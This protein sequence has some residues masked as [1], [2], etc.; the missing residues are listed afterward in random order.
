MRGIWKAQFK[1]SFCGS[2]FE[3]SC[4]IQMQCSPRCR[5]LT[6][7]EHVRPDERG[8][9]LWPKSRNVQTGYG[10]FPNWHEGKRTTLY[11]HRMAYEVANGHIPKGMRVLHKC[12]VRHC[13]NPSHLFLGTD[14][15]NTYDMA[16]KGRVG[17]GFKGF[18][19][20]SRRPISSI[21]SR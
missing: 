7:I 2:P 11:A 9:L 6:I 16:M 3:R 20:Y 19:R 21:D 13:V 15:D 5:F 17:N 8:C 10:Q 12:D 14:R 18:K 1:C 4:S